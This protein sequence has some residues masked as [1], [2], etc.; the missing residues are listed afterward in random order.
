MYCLDED[1]PCPSSLPLP[2]RHRCTPLDVTTS[3]SG[4]FAAGS[5]GPSV[6]DCPSLGANADSA[7]SQTRTLHASTPLFPCSE[8]DARLVRELQL[9]RGVRM[10]RGGVISSPSASRASSA[11]PAFGGG[12]PA[13]DSAAAGGCC[14]DGTHLP[15]PSDS[16]RSATSSS[17]ASSSAVVVAGTE[18]VDFTDS[19]GNSIDSRDSC[20]GSGPAATAVSAHLSFCNGGA[21]NPGCSDTSSGFNSHSCSDSNGHS[22]RT[23]NLPP[24]RHLHRAVVAQTGEASLPLVTLPPATFQSATPSFTAATPCSACGALIE[25]H[26]RPAA[27]LPRARTPLQSGGGDLGTNESPSCL[28]TDDADG[29]NSLVFGADSS[30]DSSSYAISTDHARP[31]GSFSNGSTNSNSNNTGVTS[32]TTS[33]GILKRDGGP[34]RAEDFNV[35]LCGIQVSPF[36]CIISSRLQ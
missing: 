16:T 35:S 30:S 2:L 22:S 25:T 13:A 23:P 19:S 32:S 1:E 15:A 4:T 20:V 21:S 7:P 17:L 29:S 34:P 11:A 10:R 33:G 8:E 5:G 28:P 36:G 24:S 14:G 9:R 31:G 3:T 26:H 12:F 27:T 6:I 18:G